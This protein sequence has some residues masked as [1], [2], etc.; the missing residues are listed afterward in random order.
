[1]SQFFGS[2]P[3]ARPPQGPKAGRWRRELARDWRE[4]LDLQQSEAEQQPQPP[5]S[6]PPPVPQP[7]KPS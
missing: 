5:S 3:A 2:N 4:A 6:P 7:P 1:M